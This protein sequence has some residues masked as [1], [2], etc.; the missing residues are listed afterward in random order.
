MDVFKD[1][2]TFV[3]NLKHEMDKSD[4]VVEQMVKRTTQ[5]TNEEQKDVTEDDHDNIVEQVL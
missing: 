3:E 2:S 4:K 1:S 5:I